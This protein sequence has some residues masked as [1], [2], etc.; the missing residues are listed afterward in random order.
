MIDARAAKSIAQQF[1]AKA[2]TGDLVLLEGRTIERGF[3]WVFFYDSK[4]FAESGEI[5]A[6]LIGNSPFIVSRKDGKVHLTR[7]AHPIEFYIRLF[8]KSGELPA[9]PTTWRHVISARE[10]DSA[11]ERGNPGK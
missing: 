3:G 1:M 4:R 11:S 2:R 7:T 10:R 9:S 8:E 6:R 5:G